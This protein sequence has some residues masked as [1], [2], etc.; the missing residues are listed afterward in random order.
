[1]TKRSLIPG[2]TGKDGFYLA[3][4]MLEAGSARAR[5]GT[6]ARR[7]G[8]LC[9]DD[10]AAGSCLVLDLSREVGAAETRPMLR[11][12][13]VGT[14]RDI[15]ILKLAQMV[16]KVAG[17]PRDAP[18][19]HDQAQRRAVQATRRIATGAPWLPRTDPSARGD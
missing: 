16:A 3:E 8:S 15:S 5:S 7:D 18:L 17:L 10:M 19:R 1:M 9:V 2:M 12:I 11:N 13:N 4:F 14:G 6:S